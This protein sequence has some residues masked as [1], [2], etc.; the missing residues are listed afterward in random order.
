MIQGCSFDKKCKLSTRIAKKLRDYSP[1][2]K[3]STQIF[4]FL[5][6]KI[7]HNMTSRNN[8]GSRPAEITD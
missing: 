6:A 2:A 5:E 1:K 8:T 7:H 3:I 4:A